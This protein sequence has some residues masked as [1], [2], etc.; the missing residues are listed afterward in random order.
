MDRKG[1]GGRKGLPGGRVDID[2][3]IG[4]EL[5][6]Q[7]DAARAG[8][9]VPCSRSR[10]VRASVVAALERLAS[11]GELRAA[12]ADAD[13][14]PEDGETVATVYTGIGT[15]GP[16]D[17]GR[18]LW[19]MRAPADMPHADAV[20]AM[21]AALPDAVVVIEPCA[22]IL[23]V[24]GRTPESVADD[25]ARGWWRPPSWASVYEPEVVS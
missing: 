17:Q 22:A 5:L 1:I 24:R 14:D 2:V 20:A 6:D 25:K 3:T 23:L 10:F 19:L 18:G 13:V 7:L 16:R 9:A 15:H 12:G 8:L 11:Q 4:R 21:R